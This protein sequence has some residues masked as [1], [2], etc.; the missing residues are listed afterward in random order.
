MYNTYL[1]SL[2]HEM[3][4]SYFTQNILEKKSNFGENGLKIILLIDHIKRAEYILIIASL[5]KRMLESG[6]SFKIL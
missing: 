1:Q 5:P 6:F 2:F 4:C 3:L